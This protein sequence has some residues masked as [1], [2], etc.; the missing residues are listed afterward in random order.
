M[1]S[2]QFD[3]TGPQLETKKP[4]EEK[5]EGRKT[6]KKEERCLCSKAPVAHAA[7]GDQP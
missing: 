6:K 5:K 2:F 4:S 1:A 3:D 7:K